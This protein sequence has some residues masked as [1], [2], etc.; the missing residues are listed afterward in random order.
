MDLKWNDETTIFGTGDFLEVDLGL[1]TETLEALIL[2]LISCQYNE[3][4]SEIQFSY[5]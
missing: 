2:A 5:V 3:T 1:P 4:V